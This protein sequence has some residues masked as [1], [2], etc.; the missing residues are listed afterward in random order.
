MIKNL[1][2]LSVVVFVFASVIASVFAFVFGIPPDNPDIAGLA[3]S[4]VFLIC[5]VV[6]IVGVIETTVKK[7]RDKRKLQQNRC[8]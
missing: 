5:V 6:L 1:M 3:V 7:I 2:C 8:S 4:I